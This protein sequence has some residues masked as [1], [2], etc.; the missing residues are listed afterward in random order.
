M[1][2]TNIGQIAKHV[3]PYPM[4]VDILLFSSSY[5]VLSHNISFRYYSFPC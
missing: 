2:C 5:I 1:R 3:M 4:S